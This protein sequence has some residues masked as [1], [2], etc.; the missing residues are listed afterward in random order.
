VENIRY[1]VIIFIFVLKFNFKVFKLTIIE[2][3]LNISY[4][5]KYSD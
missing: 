5:Q 1:S 2:N 3:Q 4:F